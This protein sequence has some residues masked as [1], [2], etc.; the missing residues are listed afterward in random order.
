MKSKSPTKKFPG[1]WFK[2]VAW[3]IEIFP[4]TWRGMHF[5][6]RT[7]MVSLQINTHSSDL[8]CGNSPEQQN[9]LSNGV[10]V[11]PSAGTPMERRWRWPDWRFW[12]VFCWRVRRW[13]RTSSGA[14]R[15]T[16]V[17]WPAA[18]RSWRL[19]WPERCQVYLTSASKTF[20]KHGLLYMLF[21]YRNTSIKIIHA[22]CPI[23]TNS[24]K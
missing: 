20:I 2:I 5:C 7:E 14:R 24:R 16:S 12:P 21:I 19:S 11:S 17:L 3:I 8:Q 23:N 15:N 1:S 9:A 18:R 4:F 13:P 22:Y 6:C 10:C